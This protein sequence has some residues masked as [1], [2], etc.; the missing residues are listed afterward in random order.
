MMWKKI[1]TRNDSENRYIA[2]P[3]I[4]VLSSEN[5]EQSRQKSEPSSEAD[6]VVRQTRVQ[7]T[8]QIQTT[9]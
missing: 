8:Q 7:R 6:T 3:V 9:D 1:Y 2:D 4:E 5:G